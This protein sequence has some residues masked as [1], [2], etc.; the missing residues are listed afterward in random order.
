MLALDLILA[1]EKVYQCQRMAL[2]RERNL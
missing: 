2:N 1:N